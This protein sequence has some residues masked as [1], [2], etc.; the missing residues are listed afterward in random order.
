MSNTLTLLAGRLAAIGIAL[1]LVA[2]GGGD[3]DIDSECIR[4]AA[5]GTAEQAQWVQRCALP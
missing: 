2:C 4:H 3:P 1:A 5:G